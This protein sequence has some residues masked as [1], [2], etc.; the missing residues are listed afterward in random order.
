MTH[1]IGECVGN[2]MHIMSTNF[3]KTLFENMSMT[4]N[5]DV[6]NSAHQIQMT[7]ICHWMN[8]PW[9][10]SA[11]ATAGKNLRS[12]KDQNVV[13]LSHEEDIHERRR[14]YFKDILNL[15]T[16]TPLDTNEVHLGEENTNTATEVF[17]AVKNTEPWAKGCRL[18]LHPTWNIKSLVQKRSFVT[19]STAIAALG[20]L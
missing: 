15:V 8:P 19:E 5:C 2:N 18:R 3:A 16:T 9:K 1:K 4:S 17:R 13:L 12:I 10:F 6:T 11:Y 7:T 20:H 14:Q